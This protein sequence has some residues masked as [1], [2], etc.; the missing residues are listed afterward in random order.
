MRLCIAPPLYSMP[1][2]VLRPRCL[3]YGVQSAEFRV[4]GAECTPELRSHSEADPTSH[5]EADPTSHSEADPTSHSEADP[6]SHSEAVPHP[7]AKRSPCTARQ[8]Y[9]TFTCFFSANNS[10][11]NCAAVMK[12]SSLAAFFI[13]SSVA[14]MS[15]S[16]SSRPM[17]FTMG[18]AAMLGFSFSM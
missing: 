18:S 16:S 11:L 8:R 9:N 15:F 13:L 1:P 3:G 12:S 7:T 6:T 14:L 2:R 4:R 10:S 17:Y 5:S